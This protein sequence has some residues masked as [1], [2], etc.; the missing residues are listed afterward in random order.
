M[1]SRLLS[2]LAEQ[3]LR[4]PRRVLLWSILPMILLGSV[5]PF[6][7][8]DLSFTGIMDRSHPQVARYFET[9]RDADLGGLLLLL[10]EG[11]DENELDR[12]VE[13]LANLPESPDVRTVLSEAPMDW[14]EQNAPYLV[15]DSVFDDWLRLATHPEDG[16]SM[17]RLVSTMS[18]KREEV[19]AKKKAGLRVVQIIMDRGPFDIDMAGGVF[20]IIEKDTKKLLE[21]FKGVTPSFAGLP[22]IAA[23]DQKSTIGAVQRL[24]PLTFL[25][26]LLLFRLVERNPMRLISVAVPMALSMAATLG[27]VGLLLGTLTV[28]ETFFGIMVFG[29]GI[30]FALHIMVRL[31]EELLAGNNF[32]DAIRIT[33]TGT[34][35]GV[36][37]G[38]L[39][40]T[41][42]FAIVGL[43]PDPAAQHM[44]VS[45]G[46]G[47]FFCLLLMLSLLPAF[48]VLLEHNG[49]GFLTG[50]GSAHVEQ[51]GSWSSKFHSSFAPVEIPAAFAVR[52]PK[53]VVF[54]TVATLIGA[55]S[56]FYRF[57]FETN[58]VKVFNRDVP[59][60]QTMDKVQEYFGINSSPWF[61]VFND[62]KSA[63]VVHELF[64]KSARFGRVESIG[65]I[66]REDRGQR[67]KRLQKS[68]AEIEAQRTTSQALL[69]LMG[70]DEKEG[71]EGLVKALNVLLAAENQGP[72]KRE[73]L[74]E[75]FRAHLFARDG[76]PIVF[77]YDKVATFD[78]ILSRESR[79]AAQKLHP[80]MTGMTAMNEVMMGLDR[81][82]LLPIFVGIL[83]FV[84]VVLAL[85]LRNL[86]HMLL[87]ATPV[88]WATTMTFG[89]LC[90]L[91]I[92]FNVLMTLVVPLLIGLGV[93]DGI[94]VVHRI[95][96]DPSTPVHLAASNVGRAI[97]MTTLTTL[98]SFSTL[99]FSNHAGMESMSEILLI[100]L[101]LCLL[102][103]VTTLPALAV[104]LK[105]GAGPDDKSD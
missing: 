64:E 93:D 17:K 24:T 96:E 90:W 23:Q 33:L 73:T 21:P 105:V 29:L 79:L 74:P 25:F 9:Q 89:I 27:L 71:L 35:R 77:A 67:H 45:G 38:A 26:V 53:L 102:S 62:V 13:A 72:P 63:L 86:K 20:F 19:S 69:P 94:H 44:G 66:L 28:M 41:G 31:R 58:L 34:G 55:L 8:L 91:G 48:W 100:G 6:L 18:K 42:A 51:Q 10:L 49:R 99:L 43:A 54:I 15:D 5:A 82:W 80:E 36:V 2:L 52:H 46:V 3:V 32:D 84:I 1:I 47:L 37:A 97:F 65:S 40:T 60:V 87:A 92:S 88:L 16:E 61:A 50:K 78:A 103:S 95:R 30:D 104:L 14:L 76:R 57:H 4:H 101:P 39:T 70:D 68:K 75:S 98:V 56:G 59:A 85:D 81:P 12:A 7:P 83:L 22:A 11:D